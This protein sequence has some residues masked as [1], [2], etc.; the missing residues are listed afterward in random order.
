MS[1]PEGCYVYVYLDGWSP[2]YIGAGH[3]YRVWAHLCPSAQ[4]YHGSA[5]YLHL[6]KMLD[7]G[8]RPNILI[9]KEG[10][11][12]K[13]GAA[14]E[15]ALIELVGTRRAGTGTLFNIVNPLRGDWGSEAVICWG[16][17]F[18]SWSAAARDPR[19]VVSAKTLCSRVAC[20]VG[21]K[22]AAETPAGEISKVTCWGE[23]FYS[24]WQLSQDKRCLT[25]Y[26]SLQK[27]VAAGANVQEATETP[28]T[29]G[30]K[31]V[32]CW[33]EEFESL[34]ALSRDPR[35]V[36]SYIT[37]HKRVVSGALTIGEAAETHPQSLKQ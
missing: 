22:E 24:V 18:Y 19:C 26:T 1:Y 37:P 32:T 36:V 9:V 31:V 5:F 11:T 3:G 35:C 28:P 6:Q 16:E 2:I 23:E 20:G 10:L 29:R 25:S 12:T 17:E 27:R 30:A 7:A 14:S 8:G 21:I 13:A 4:R 15:A 34:I 33:G